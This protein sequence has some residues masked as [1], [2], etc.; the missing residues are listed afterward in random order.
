[1]GICFNRFRNAYDSYEK[2][3]QNLETLPKGTTQGQ[4]RL[5]RKT[6]WSPRTLPR[7][8]KHYPENKSAKLPSPSS[9]PSFPI[10]KSPERLWPHNWISPRILSN[11]TSTLSRPGRSSPTSVP[12]S[13]ATGRYC[14]KNKAATGR[15]SASSSIRK[16]AHATAT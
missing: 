16:I 3:T 14:S 9:M 7:N 11:T 1:M 15:W 10:P 8:R 13:E 6:D 12:T 2:T 5:P 4:K